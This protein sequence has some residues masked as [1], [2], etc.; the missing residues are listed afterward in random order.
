M[1]IYGRFSVLGEEESHHRVVGRGDVC[2]VKDELP[3]GCYIDLNDDIYELSR[4]YSMSALAYI[5]VSISVSGCRGYRC[6]R[7]C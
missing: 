7:C 6:G 4:N 3:A 2:W 5:N 1:N